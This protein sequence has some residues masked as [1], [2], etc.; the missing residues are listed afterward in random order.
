[1]TIEAEII[2]QGPLTDRE[3]EI[4]RLMAEGHA[5][6]AIAR[7]LA[8]SIKT[9][10]VHTSNIY[11]KLQVHADSARANTAAINSRCLA[12][13]KMIA[14]K[15]IG[16]SVKLTALVLIFSMAQLD[17]EALRARSGRVR[18]KVSVSRLRKDA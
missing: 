11:L 2:D 9:V 8:I 14:K 5:D 7:L 16:V 17:D 10:N 15:M 4:A 18:V 3:A 12:V 13:S 1:M 6:K